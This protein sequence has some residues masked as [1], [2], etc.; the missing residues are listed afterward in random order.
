MNPPG[1][2]TAFREGCK[3]SMTANQF[4]L[5]TAGGIGAKQ[6]SISPECPIHAD[7]ER[8]SYDITTRGPGLEYRKDRYSGVNRAALID[9]VSHFRLRRNLPVAD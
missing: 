1:S 4:G 5:G 6:W 3:C 9:P 2:F 7:R 8:S